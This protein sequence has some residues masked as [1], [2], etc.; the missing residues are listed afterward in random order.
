MKKLL[1]AGLFLAI[2]TVSKSFCAMAGEESQ[3]QIEI[4][5][6]EKQNLFI[7]SL[8]EE[9]ANIPAFLRLRATS[10]RP[11]IRW[12]NVIKLGIFFTNS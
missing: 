3:K 10:M 6:V 5:R 9:L 4:R 2:L 8:Q 1:S 12:Q 11:N 7:Q